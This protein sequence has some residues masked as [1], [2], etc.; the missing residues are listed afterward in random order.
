MKPASK[1]LGNPSKAAAYPS[2]LVDKAAAGAHSTVDL[3]AGSVPS[4]IDQV[5]SGAHNTVDLAA[6]ALQPAARKIGNFA[7]RLNNTSGTVLTG[8]KQYV[9]DHPF[10]T[11]ASAVVLGILFSNLTRRRD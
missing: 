9:N 11:L 3:I 5:A 1:S 7:Q 6:K 8:T 4:V 10:L 2:A